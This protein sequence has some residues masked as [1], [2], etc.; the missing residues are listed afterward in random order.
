MCE[1]VALAAPGDEFAIDDIA[2][3]GA[4][5]ARHA[6]CRQWAERVPPELKPIDGQAAPKATAEPARIVRAESGETEQGVIIFEQPAAAGQDNLWR[7]LEG[8]FTEHRIILVDPLLLGQPDRSGI[9]GHRQVGRQIVD[10]VILVNVIGLALVKSTEEHTEAIFGRRRNPDLVAHLLEIIGAGDVLLRIDDVAR[11]IGVIMIIKQPVIIVVGIVNIISV[12]VIGIIAGAIG[13]PLQI[14]TRI[15]QVEIGDLALDG[16]GNLRKL[17]L[18]DFR[19]EAL[20]LQVT[21]VVV[22][23]ED[24]AG[25]AVLMQDRWGHCP[26]VVEV[27][28]ERGPAAIGAQV[29]KILLDQIAVVVDEIGSI[30]VGV[31]ARSQDIV[32]IAAVALVEGDAAEC[33]P[34]GNRQVDHAFEAAAPIAMADLVDLGVEAA[35]GHA[36]FGLV[37][38][39]ADRPGLRRRAVQRALR[40]GEALDPGDVVDMHVE[41]AADGRHRLLVEVGADRRQRARVVAVAA[42]GD[43]AHVDHRRSGLRRLVADRRQQLGVILEIRDVELVEPPRSDRLDADRHVLQILFALGRGDDDD[44]AVAVAHLLAGRV[45]RIGGRC[46][47]RRGLGEGG[48]CQRG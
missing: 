36:Q 24:A 31:G 26:I 41:R 40:P 17:V 19:E 33:D 20:R 37:A 35:R 30:G 28:L 16:Q 39:D 13:R 32:D 25:L 5:C 18:A 34:V 44:I 21:L 7:D 42:G 14:S 1:P 10:L 4:R 47:G 23:K 38:D 2:D 22:L 27:D 8:R 48:R 3:V 45:G 15:G 29:V 6:A 46:G 43:A 9:A 12:G 11:V